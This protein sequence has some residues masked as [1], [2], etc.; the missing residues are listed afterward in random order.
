MMQL[1]FTPFPELETERLLL[2]KL[3]LETDIQAVFALLSNQDNQR[4]LKRPL[5][6]SLEEAK[7]HIIRMNKGAEDDKWLVWAI[8]KEQQLVGTICLWNFTEAQQSG[9]IGYELHPD[10]QKLGYMTEAIEAV[11]QYGIHKIGLQ[12]FRAITEAL[13]YSSVQLLKKHDFKL[14]R[15]LSDEEK[16]GIA[17]DREA[18]LYVKF[19]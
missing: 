8:T 1:N 15:I 17:K 10:F 16:W 13:N 7:Q 2:R 14:K 5:A 6:Q 11:I 18:H 9:E 4:Y 12:Q 19:C 3:N